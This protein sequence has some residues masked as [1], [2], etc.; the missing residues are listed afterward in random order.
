MEQNPEA[1]ADKKAA[2]EKWER[3][4]TMYLDKASKEPAP[5]YATKKR[6]LE[7]E[8]HNREAKEK[9]D[10]AKGAKEKEKSLRKR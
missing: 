8:E 3:Q 7:D 4:I 5:W 10:E 9:L 6:T 2:D 1:V